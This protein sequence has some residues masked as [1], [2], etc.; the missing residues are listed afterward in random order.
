MQ[1]VTKCSGLKKAPK[2]IRGCITAGS[3]RETASGHRFF[4]ALPN[5]DQ[6][7]HGQLT[8]DVGLHFTRRPNWRPDFVASWVGTAS[9][10]SSD[11]RSMKEGSGAG[12]APLPSILASAK[13]RVVM[14]LTAILLDG[15]VEVVLLTRVS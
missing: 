13:I 14:L 6:A 2:S 9:S 10:S 8:N 1:A 12:K 7:R 5:V 3:P 15:W 4:A 11:G